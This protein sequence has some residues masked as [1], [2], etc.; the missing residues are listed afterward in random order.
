MISIFSDTTFEAEQVQIEL[1]RQAPSW[2]KFEMVAQ[3]NQTV[4]LLMQEGLRQRFPNAS[5]GEIRRRLADLILGPELGARIF[6]PLDN[7]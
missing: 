1:L 3:M 6:G 2:R 7:T 5:E 4:R